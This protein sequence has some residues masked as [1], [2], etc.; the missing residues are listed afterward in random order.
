MFIEAREITRR[1]G[2]KEIDE[3]V[4]FVTGT[5]IKP[6]YKATKAPLTETLADIAIL[7]SP[8]LLVVVGP[9]VAATVAAI[10]VLNKI[11][12]ALAN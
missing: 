2:H 12:K 11:R 6:E 8:I 3:A 1:P 9:E 4:A 7:T 5:N 10:F